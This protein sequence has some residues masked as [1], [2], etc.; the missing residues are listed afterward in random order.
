MALADILF[1]DAE[2]FVQTKNTPST[3]GPMRNMMKNCQA[4]LMTF[5]KYVIL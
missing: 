3:E 2:P 4:G 5:K 1:N